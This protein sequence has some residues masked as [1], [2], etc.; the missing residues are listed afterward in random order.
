MGSADRSD[1]ISKIPLLIDSTRC[2]E[3]TKVFTLLI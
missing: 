3:L 2:V 1:S